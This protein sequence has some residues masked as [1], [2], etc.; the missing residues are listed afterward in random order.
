[1]IELN[2]KACSYAEENVIKVLKEA[3]AKVYTDG[4]RDG[5]KDCQNHV[6]VNLR[7]NNTEYV[8]LGLPSGTL[9]S[10]DYEKE[11]DELVYIPHDVALRN[12]IPT[13]EQCLEL[14]N[15]CRFNYDVIEGKIYCI[16]PN[17]NS[18]TFSPTS[19]KERGDEVIKSATI[20][21]FWLC[22]KGEENN[23]NAGAIGYNRGIWHETRNLFSGYKLPIRLVKKK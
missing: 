17:G 2:E 8:D 1:M 16:G 4:Y 21:Y 10:A 20:C 14:Y 9:W 22:N 15:C 6:S 5:Y 3:F 11:G 18:V 19:Y 23:H 12:M 13:S 7:I